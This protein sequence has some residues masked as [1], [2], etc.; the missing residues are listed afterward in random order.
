MSKIEWDKVGER[1]YETGVDRGVLYLLKHGTY[2]KGVPW[3][4]LIGATE[5][6]SGAEATPVYADNIKYLNLISNEE[7]K[8][9][10][11]AYSYPDEFDECIGEIELAKGV[12][13]GQQKRRHF[14]FC[15]RS[16]IGN[17]TDGPDHGYK[18]RLIF[19]CIAGPSDRSHNSINESPEASSYSWE[20][21]TTPVAIEG[22]KP[23]SYLELDSTKFV[24]DGIRN[25]LTRIEDVLYGSKGKNPRFPKV[26]E[27]LDIFD[28]EINLKDSEN[29]FML[30]S[31][32][33]R[34]QSRVFN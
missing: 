10:I 13:I 14:G 9:T 17:D 6:P 19:D 8:E 29:D 23:S 30:D 33:N 15:Y 18:L 27:I 26:S 3:N 24:K 31:S 22:Y 16:M 12:A 34:L 20:L 4:G 11:E 25:V 1:Y 21:T 5:N 32:G 7:H 28:Q 2:S